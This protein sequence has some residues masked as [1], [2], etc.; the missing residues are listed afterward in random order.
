MRSQTW[1]LLPGCYGIHCPDTP[2]FAARML[3]DSLPGCCENMHLYPGLTKTDLHMKMGM[4]KERQK[5][6]GILRWKEPEQ[7]VAQ[8]VK[9]MEKRKAICIGGW[10]KMKILLMGCMP[11]P[12]YYRLISSMSK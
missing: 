1:L 2:R 6:K 9:A 5:N 10:T 8:S 7:V 3:Q 11:K 12:L 4:S